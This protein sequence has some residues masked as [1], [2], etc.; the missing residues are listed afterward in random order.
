[1][2]IQPTGCLGV[3]LRIFG[4]GADAPASTTS[5]PKVQINK[6]FVSNAEGDFFR[7]LRRV[8]GDRGHQTE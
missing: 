3:L 5:L 1:M 6:Y 4:V 8:V 7:V 2:P